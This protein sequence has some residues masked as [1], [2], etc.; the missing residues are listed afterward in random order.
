[1]S[2]AFQQYVHKQVDKRIKLFVPC[3]DG[4]LKDLIEEKAVEIADD[5]RRKE[6]I[7]FKRHK[8][9]ATEASENLAEY[10]DLQ[11]LEAA[12]FSDI[13]R[14]PG[15]LAL[16]IETA[17]PSHRHTLEMLRDLVHGCLG[18][19]CGDLAIEHEL[20]ERSDCDD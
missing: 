15:I 17:P 16:A 2:T 20:H 12:V 6:Y 7:D 14:N 3:D 18:V 10:D 8:W 4:D 13:I 5:I 1:M 11:K 9:T 19:M